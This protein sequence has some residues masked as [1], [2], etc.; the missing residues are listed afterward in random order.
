MFGQVYH[1]DERVGVE[2]MEFPTFSSFSEMMRLAVGFDVPDD[3]VRHSSK[4]SKEGV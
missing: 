1:T 2:T 3:K 4:L